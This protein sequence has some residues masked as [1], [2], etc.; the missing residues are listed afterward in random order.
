MTESKQTISELLTG[1]YLPFVIFGIGA[2]MLSWVFFA[3]D[4]ILG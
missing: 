1:D 4:L 2:T 3:G